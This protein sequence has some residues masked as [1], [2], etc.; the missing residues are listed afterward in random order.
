MKLDD[1]DWHE[2]SLKKGQP[3]AH[4]GT[5]IALFIQWLAQGDY[6]DP[7][8]DFNPTSVEAL[9]NGSMSA[10]SF[11]ET[12]CDGKLFDDMVI[13]QMQA[14][15]KAYYSTKPLKSW[16]TYFI[17]IEQTIIGKEKLY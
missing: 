12:E 10:Y 13:P 17:D 16:T 2:G 9:K 5:H 8:A 1:V 4:A 14:F 3:R 15:L 7:K 11:L 6:L